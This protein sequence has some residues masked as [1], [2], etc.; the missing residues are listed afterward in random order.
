MWLPVNADNC[1]KMSVSFAKFLFCNKTVVNRFILTVD[2]SPFKSYSLQWHWSKVVLVGE[3]N[4]HQLS[5]ANDRTQKWKKSHRES[6]CWVLLP[7]RDAANEFVFWSLLAIHLSVQH[8]HMFT[9]PMH[10]NRAVVFSI[11]NTMITEIISRETFPGDASRQLKINRND[12]YFTSLQ[13]VLLVC[14]YTVIFY[15]EENRCFLCG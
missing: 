15:P 12:E 10:C 3:P 6:Q 9:I 14:L 7:E 2:L 5:S 13:T 11:E 4:K 8:F 1:F